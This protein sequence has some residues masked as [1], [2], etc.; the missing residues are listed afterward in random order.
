MG[1]QIIVASRGKWRDNA[2]SDTHCELTSIGERRIG[3]DQA[4]AGLL[5]PHEKVEA[6][7]A[8]K[9]EATRRQIELENAR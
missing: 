7:F 9:V 2:G 3:L 4:N 6:Y 8:A 1:E 5:I